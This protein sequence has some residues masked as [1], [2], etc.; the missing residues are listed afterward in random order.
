MGEADS[1]PW[2]HYRGFYQVT[3]LFIFLIFFF[4]MSGGKFNNKK[5]VITP[6]SP[7]T[8]KKTV[9]LSPKT[10]L[11]LDGLQAELEQ[12]LQPLRQRMAEVQQLYVNR[13]TD[14]VSGFLDGIGIDV[15]FNLD[16][17]SR[18]DDGWNLI[19]MFAR[20][21]EVDKQKI[22]GETGGNEIQKECV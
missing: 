18:S 19:I 7:M 3:L 10:K 15:D 6:R 5:Q 9:K 11:R 13:M 12:A 14:T 1:V 17:V 4:L 8:T 20:S 21:V 2:G 22:D 16:T